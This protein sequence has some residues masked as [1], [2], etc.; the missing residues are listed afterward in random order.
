MTLDPHALARRITHDAANLP[1]ALRAWQTNLTATTRDGWPAN[2][3]PDPIGRGG[4]SDRTGEHATTNTTGTGHGYGPTDEWTLVCTQLA[5]AAAA[6]EIVLDK[7]K[8]RWTNTATETQRCSGGHLPGA[9]QTLA[10]GGW[11]DPACERPASLYRR[12]DGGY[13]LRREGL[14]DTCAMRRYRAEQ[15]GVAA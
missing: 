1:T 5:I 11:H 2:S 12:D 8:A 14:C 9:H 4:I 15:R 7:L 10:E 13:S 3:N 6:L